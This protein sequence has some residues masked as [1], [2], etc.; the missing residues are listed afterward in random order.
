MC[1]DDAYVSGGSGAG[2]SGRRCYSRRIAAGY[3][4]VDWEVLSERPAVVRFARFLDG[5][6]LDRIA[7]RMRTS[8]YAWLSLVGS[9]AYAYIT[10]QNNNI[11]FI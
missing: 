5:P 4:R 7:E 1:V 3:E 6:A 9:F 11:G 10:Q 2:N 8:K